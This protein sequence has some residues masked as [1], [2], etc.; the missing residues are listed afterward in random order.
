ME[1]QD[2][3][4]RDEASRTGFRSFAFKRFLIAAIMIAL[5]IWALS[6]GPGMIPSSHRGEL[7]DRAAE[8]RAHSTD[9]AE[10][11]GEST[12]THVQA[13]EE[14]SAPTHPAVAATES[15]RSAEMASATA[16]HARPATEMHA[17]ETRDAAAHPAEADHEVAAGHAAVAD[18]AA[19]ADHAA[20]T[21]KKKAGDHEPAAESTAKTAESTHK[22]SGAPPEGGAP[23]AETAHVEK[24]P[25][26]TFVEAVIQPLSHELKEHFWGW[27]PNDILNITDNVNNYQKGVLEVTRRSV[28]LLSER[29]SRT[30]S[31]D[32][33]NPHLENAMN[34]LMVKADRYWFPSPESKYKESIA[35]LEKYRQALVNGTASFH[36]R[37]DNI[38]P[39]L[40]SYEDLLG[41]CDENLV[42]QKE[43][44][45]TRV[46]YFKAD[47]Y[48][49]YAQGVAGAMVNIL[50]AIHHDFEAT[51]ESRH[52]TGL[53]HHAIES[54]HQAASLD[55]LLI[56]NGDLDGIFANHRAHMAA[57]ISHARF[58]IGQLIKTLST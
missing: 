54:C 12:G 33:F 36:T 19:E 29:I 55:P 35:E 43:D 20:A 52:A 58:Y 53:L 11:H 41:S 16:G 23:A 14:E 15:S 57:P 49:F 5:V 24:K 47:D 27:R 38:I 50:T 39:L 8:D 44:D 25:G 4:S 18:R 40:A 48:F 46:S 1:H 13:M 42:K 28:V 32:S 26:V 10:E 7:P 21:G 37:T 17:T 30:G 6:I 2:N 34:W 51:L 56:T 45:G 9:V 22:P 3:D 31:T